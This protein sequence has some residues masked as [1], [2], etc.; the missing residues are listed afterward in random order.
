LVFDELVLTYVFKMNLFDGNVFCCYRVNVVRQFRK[1][2]IFR[3]MVWVFINHSINII[4]RFTPLVVNYKLWSCSSIE[5]YSETLTNKLFIRL[6]D[7]NVGIKKFVN[8]SI[9]NLIKQN[10]VIFVLPWA[11]AKD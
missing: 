1:T 3:M 10:I 5:V 11:V 9:G 2:H 6:A 7:L 4:N 8:D